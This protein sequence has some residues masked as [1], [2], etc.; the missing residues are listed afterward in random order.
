[1]AKNYIR[2]AQIS[3]IH[4]NNQKNSI[5]RGSNPYNNLLNTLAIIKKNCY[6]YLIFSGDVSEDGSPES[7]ALVKS[8]IKNID[9]PCYFIHGNHDNLTNMTKVFQPLMMTSFVPL[10]FLG[11]ELFFLDTTDGNN[12]YGLISN[13]AYLNLLQ[14]IK[15]SNAN[16]IGL[17]M[18]HQPSTVGTPLTDQFKIKNDDLIGQLIEKE[19]IEIIIFG[20]VHNDYEFFIKNTFCSSAPAVCL[21]FIKGT[22]TLSIDYS[23]GYKEYIFTKT[24]VNTKCRWFN[25]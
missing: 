21:Q 9:V 6:D 3:D 4:M 17:I 10:S 18:H 15:N 23:F 14:R 24:N 12:P 19:K 25:I 5:F 22:D 16:K 20:H 2:I 7:Y 1:M 11:W 8:A 13:E